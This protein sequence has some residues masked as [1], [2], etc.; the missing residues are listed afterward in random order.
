MATMLIHTQ[1]DGGEGVGLSGLRMRNNG[2]NSRSRATNILLFTLTG[3]KKLEWNIPRA[4][5]ATY[6]PRATTSALENGQRVLG[7]FGVTRGASALMSSLS[8][9][10]SLTLSRLHG[11]GFMRDTNA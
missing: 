1:Y 2:K 11:R 8:S 7:V 9:S 10:L 6:V 3:G 5:P 4:S